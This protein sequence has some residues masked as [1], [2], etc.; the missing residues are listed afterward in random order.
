MGFGGG[1]G[2]YFGIVVDRRNDFEANV[3]IVNSHF[4]PQGFHFVME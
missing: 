2:V 4:V 3:N 1:A